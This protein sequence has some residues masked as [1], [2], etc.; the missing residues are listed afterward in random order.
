MTLIFYRIPFDSG[1]LT[2]TVSTATLALDGTPATGDRH[3]LIATR[4]ATQ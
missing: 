3:L 1:D 2:A 4:I